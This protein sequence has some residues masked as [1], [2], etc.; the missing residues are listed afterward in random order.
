M[1]QAAYAV[2]SDPAKRA[3]YD[4]ARSGAPPISTGRR[5]PSVMLRRL[6]GNLK[7]LLASGF[8]RYAAD[9]LIE[10][11]LTAQEAAEGGM[12]T[13]AMRVRARCP[14]CASDAAQSC[15]TCRSTRMI[16]ELY[17]AWLAVPPGV[18][19]GAILK[20]SALLPGMVPISF[21]V[22]LQGPT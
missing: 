3:A 8:A 2:L 20:P 22:R 15:A 13:I 9:D 7:G 5:V 18:I 6:S 17:S 16:D 1:I 14:A 19:D 10:L 21:R 4:R 12:I 11:F